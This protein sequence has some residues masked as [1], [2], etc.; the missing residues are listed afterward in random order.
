[1]IG[2]RSRRVN[3]WRPER[4]RPGFG[5]RGLA[6]GWRLAWAAVGVAVYLPG[7]PGFRLV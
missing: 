7:I 3:R 1:M 2:K 6:W 5:G 4:Q